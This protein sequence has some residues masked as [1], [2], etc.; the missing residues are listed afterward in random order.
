M[1]REEAHKLKYGN[2]ESKIFSI[3]NLSHRILRGTNIPQNEKN[4]PQNIDLFTLVGQ[5][6]GKWILNE[7]EVDSLKN[8]EFSVQASQVNFN[9]V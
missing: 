2:D 8:I 1:L 9:P 5:E 6:E 7:I 3:P 4:K